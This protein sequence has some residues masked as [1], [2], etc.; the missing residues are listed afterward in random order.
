MVAWFLE[1]WKL[2]ALII[3][4]I[5]ILGVWAM[6]KTFAKKDNVN[7]SIVNLDKRIDL[8]DAA[9]GNLPDKDLTHKLELRI[10]Q[11][12]G[13]I[14]RIEPGLISVKNLSDMLLENELKSKG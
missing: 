10:E 4:A 7:E 11:L 5:F 13:D 1:Y 8:L 2:L 14:K 9:V 3:N 12:S 6:S